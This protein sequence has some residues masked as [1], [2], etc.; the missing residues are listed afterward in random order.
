MDFYIKQHKYYC[1]IDL[2]T[3]KMRCCIVNQK[4]EELINTNLDCDQNIFKRSTMV[5]HKSTYMAHIRISNY[6]YNLPPFK[7][8][9]LDI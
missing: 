7:T 5:S 8:G 2:H 4:N 3:S 9:G 6:Q 1:G